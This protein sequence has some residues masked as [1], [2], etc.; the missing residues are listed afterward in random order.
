MKIVGIGGGTG[1][2]ALLS[3][4]KELND[5]GE[6]PIDITAIVA[7]SDSGGSTGALRRA[8]GM[9]AVGDI[10][11]CLLSLSAADPILTSVCKHRF[12]SADS[13]AGH[14]VGNLI[15]SALFQMSDGFENAVRRASQLLCVQGRVLPATEIPLT[16]YGLREVGSIGIGEA[17]IPRPGVS[18]NRVWVEPSAPPASGVLQSLAEADVIDIGPGSLFTSIIPNFL[19][20]GIPDA[21][22][23][24]DARKVYVCNL[25]TEPGE[26]DGYSAANHIRTL[27]SYLPPDSID[28]CILN[29]R[30]IGMRLADRYLRSGSEVVSAAPEDEDEIRRMGV[31]PA[32]ATLLKDEETKA[33]HD[34]VA[35]AR[36]ITSIA[37]G[38]ARVTR[39]AKTGGMGGNRCAESS[40]I[41]VP[42]KSLVF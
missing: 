16:L 13:L 29:S 42:E 35:L 24:S 22:K 25:M 38:R 8:F 7:V 4:L 26:T 3:G 23:A 27:Q 6:G 39:P 37:R 10:R 2:P 11:N 30:G 32:F 21:I 5:N 36:V 14:S 41:S 1:L 19:V 12:D 34:A 40:D 28:I 20:A 9:P 31:I 15:L 18:V 33:R 17:N